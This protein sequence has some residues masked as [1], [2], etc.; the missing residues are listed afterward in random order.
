MNF[1]LGSRQLEISMFQLF[2]QKQGTGSPQYNALS[3][4]RRLPQNRNMAC[5]NGS[6]LNCVS[7]IEANPSIPRRRSVYPQAISIGQL[8]YFPFSRALRYCFR[9]RTIVISSERRQWCFYCTAVKSFSRLFRW[10]NGDFCVRCFQPDIG[11]RCGRWCTHMSAA[12]GR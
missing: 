4:S 10:P 5:W 8:L 6:I 1:V 9:W 11:G 3:R 2:I 12:A 7:T